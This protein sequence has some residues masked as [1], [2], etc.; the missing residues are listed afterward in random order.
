[1]SRRFLQ[2]ILTAVGLTAV[3]TGAWGIADAVAGY[4]IS[5]RRA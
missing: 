2:A 1:M 5:G 4:E 3:I